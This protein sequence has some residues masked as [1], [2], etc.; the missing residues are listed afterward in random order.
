MIKKLLLILG[1]IACVLAIF[2]LLKYV[3][4]YQQLSEYGRGY[5]WGKV[6]L[7]LVGILLIVASQ[8]N[9]KGAK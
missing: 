2:P 9:R 7:L 1:I 3:F 4:D 8:Y 5:I 6:S